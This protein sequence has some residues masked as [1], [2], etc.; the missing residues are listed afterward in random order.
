[1]T[2]A[3]ST[4]RSVET[5]LFVRIEC[6]HYKA[7]S[8]ASSYTTEI[9]KFSDYIRTV[10]IGGESYVGLGRLMGITSSTSEIKA[11]G[12]QVTITISGIPNTSLYEIVNSRLK[13]SKVKVYRAF[14]NVETGEVLNI[15]TPL[16]G[17]FFGIVDNYSLT[18]DYN[19][20][21]KTSTN[22]ISIMCSSIIDV[23]SNT[24]KGRRTNPADQKKYNPADLSM[25]RIP[26]LV[27]S[28]FNFGA[29]KI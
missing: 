17:R 21:S 14:F 20:D 9:F 11:S 4:L 6:D 1:M 18:E 7:N 10:V 24:T 26:S 8:S 13:G 25:D 5:G 3:I 27:G 29:P 15:D 2:V 19:Y 23:L 16:V 28:Y 22:T 12:N